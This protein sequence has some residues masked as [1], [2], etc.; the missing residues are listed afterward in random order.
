MRR[1]RFQKWITRDDLRANRKTMY[2]FGDNCLR[3]GYGGQAKEMRDEP[4][5]CGIR[6]KKAPGMNPDSFFSDV[7]FQQNRDMIMNDLNPVWN[8]IQSGGDVVCPMDGLGTGLSNLV[9]VAPRTAKFLEDC[10]ANLAVYG[11]REE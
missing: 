7:E 10:I 1:F 2:L 9:N 11:N 4:N 8:H 5:A 3:L 6:T